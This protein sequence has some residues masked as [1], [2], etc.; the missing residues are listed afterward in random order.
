MT[1]IPGLQ[2]PFGIQPVNPTPVDSWSGPY[3]GENEVSALTLANSSIPS[4]VRFK[5]MEVRLIING[6]SKKYWYRDGINDVDL[7]E[8]TSGS[9]AVNF[10]DS[11]T[12]TFTQ[13]GDTYSAF[14]IEGS[15]TASSLNT[16]SNGGATAGYLL[17][18]DGLGNFQWVD[19]SATEASI[20]VA[21]YLTGQTFSGVQNIIFR[22]G[23]VN[24]PVGGTA[25]GV[26]VTNGQPNTV[27]VWIPAP[28]YVRNFSPSLFGGVNRKISN[29]TI[30]SYTASI[31][32]GTFEIGNWLP[33]DTKPSTNN[34]N[35]QLF[36]DVEF[37]CIDENTTIDFILYK[38]DG[39]TIIDQIIGFNINAN[40]GTT[41]SVGL[42]MNLLSF[43]PDADRFKANITGSVNFSQV[44]PNGG[45]F[46]FKVVHNNGSQQFPFEVKD[47]FFDN[48]TGA[49]SAEINGQVSL[50]ENIPVL[51]FIS[52]VAYYGV[53][54]TFTASV[55]DMDN[56]N[57]I[58][59]PVGDQLN[60][61]FNQMNINN[62]GIQA[63]GTGYIGWNTNWNIQ[64]VNFIRSY[65]TT[66]NSDI[67]GLNSNN[68]ELA[69]TGSSGLTAKINDWS[70]NVDSKQSPNYKFMFMNINS[71]SDRNTEDFRNETR[72]LKVSNAI[73][74]NT[75][76]FNSQNDRLISNNLELQQIYGRLVY[77]KIDFREWGPNYNNVNSINYSSL[78]NSSITIPVINNIS[79]L[80][81]TNVSYSDYRWYL[82][83]FETPGQGSTMAN[84][85]FEFNT[86]FSESDL[87]TKNDGTP[88]NSNLLIYMGLTNNT[89]PDKWYDL[90]K[91]SISSPIAGPRSNATGAGSSN[92]D[93]TPKR[94]AWNTGTIGGWTCYLLIGIKNTSLNSSISQIDITGG[95]WN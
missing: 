71:I 34:N 62:V 29:P 36:S 72:R 53:G 19:P 35:P 58:T 44:I 23:S 59:Y 33:G 28:N 79:T 68:N 75:T 67:P 76:S 7:V 94:I 43:S 47:R 20:T 88:G 92:L 84:G 82:R 15:L 55:L 5:S 60:L 40:N 66:G 2:L 30:N 10:E 91:S 52:G 9:G 93:S 31:S 81:I 45:R 22:G 41:Q 90:S 16:G 1:L 13:S 6:V 54:S 85:V 39:T 18:N 89:M 27:T 24:V 49:S 4:A 21:D 56:L 14:I 11:D 78:S 48:D 26:N 38:A 69:T 50:S 51:R 83:R 17:S 64:N 65:A 87:I 73:S 80:S 63:G 86:T 32:A 77:P 25:T 37:S 42:S 8:F 70:L 57:E 95:S 74:G 61:E 12:I 46:S 3:S